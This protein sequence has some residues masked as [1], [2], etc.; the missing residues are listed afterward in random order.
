MQRMTGRAGDLQAKKLLCRCGAQ[1]LL[2]YPGRAIAG[3]VK[4]LAGLESMC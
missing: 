4:D 3:P 2:A 1:L